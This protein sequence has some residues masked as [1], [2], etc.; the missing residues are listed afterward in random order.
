MAILSHEEIDGTLI[1]L[2][3]AYDDANPQVKCEK[4]EEENDMPQ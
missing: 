2:S 3:K 4:I 1:A